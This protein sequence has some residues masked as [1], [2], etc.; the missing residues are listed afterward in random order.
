MEA[1]SAL[2]AISAGR[3]LK[4]SD[5]EL[6]LSLVCAWINVWVNKREAGDLRRYRA[7]YDITVMVTVCKS[8]DIM[9]VVEIIAPICRQG[10]CYNHDDVGWSV[11][12]P[13]G[14]GSA[15]LM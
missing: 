13:Q 11:P 8:R 2:L 7:H 3:N 15:R 12:L 4:A 10:I 6:F 1:F 14:T 9:S 5:V